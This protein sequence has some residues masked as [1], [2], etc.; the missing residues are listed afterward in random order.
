MP[1]VVVVPVKALRHYQC[2]LCGIGLMG[3]A[4]MLPDENGYEHFCNNCNASLYLPYKYPTMETR[5]MIL[6][7]EDTLYVQRR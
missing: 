2:D 6:P 5:E 3:N 4:K 1:E 7:L